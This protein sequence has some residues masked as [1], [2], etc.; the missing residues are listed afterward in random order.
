MQACAIRKHINITLILKLLSKLTVIYV[1]FYLCVVSISIL[2][3]K[4]SIQKLL[5]PLP[6]SCYDIPTVNIWQIFF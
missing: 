3:C 6:Q 1:N 2:T 5:L 4:V